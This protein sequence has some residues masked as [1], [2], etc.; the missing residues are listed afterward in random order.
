MHEVGWRCG[1]RSAWAWRGIAGG[2]LVLAWQAQ[3]CVAAGSASGGGE[4][5]DGDGDQASRRRQQTPTAATE[6]HAPMTKEQAKEL[7]R[8]VDEIL[9]FVS[10]DTKLPIEHQRE[11]QADHRATR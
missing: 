8:S 9:N 5:A 3:R 7:F 1:V 4:R 11:A 6:T 10:K 2:V